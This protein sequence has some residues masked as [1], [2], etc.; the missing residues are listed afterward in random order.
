[1]HYNHLTA[2][3]QEQIQIALEKYFYQ[4]FEINENCEFYSPSGMQ[5]GYIA[6]NP[7]MHEV[8]VCDCTPDDGDTLI[9][10]IRY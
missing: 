8:L 9:A 6:F 10:T 4:R 3:T 7:R 2:E 5:Y 1:M